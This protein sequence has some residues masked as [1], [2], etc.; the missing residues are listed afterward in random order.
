[1]KNDII[2]YVF[3]LNGVNQYLDLTNF[4]LYIVALSPFGTEIPFGYNSESPDSFRNYEKGKL[5]IASDTHLII[6]DKNVNTDDAIVEDDEYDD[7]KPSSLQTVLEFQEESGRCTVVVW[8][9][10][11]VICL[12]FES[13]DF[14]CFDIDGTTILEHKVNIILQLY[15]LNYYLIYLIIITY[16]VMNQLLYLS[17]YHQF[18]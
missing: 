4:R 11:N 18:H 2:R 15:Y 1:M 3:S 5:A 14:A 16:R 9:A 13:G 17:N 8:L 6:T 12:G 7:G 10:E